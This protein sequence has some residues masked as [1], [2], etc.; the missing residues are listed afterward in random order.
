MATSQTRIL[1]KSGNARMET[2]TRSGGISEIQEDRFCFLFHFLYLYDVD[3]ERLLDC[4][5]GEFGTRL[6]AEFDSE[7]H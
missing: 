7:A 4:I 1:S 3:L 2:R 5:Y 6:S